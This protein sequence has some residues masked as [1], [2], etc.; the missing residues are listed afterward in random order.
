M[1][2][3]QRP[4]GI[5]I[6]KKFGE[7]EAELVGEQDDDKSRDQAGDRS[8][9]RNPRK[10]ANCQR[11]REQLQ[12]RREG[13]GADLSLRLRRIGRAEQGEQ[14]SE[15]DADAAEQLL[16]PVACR[17]A[18]VVTVE[19]AREHGAGGGNVD[20]RGSLRRRHGGDGEQPEK[21]RRPRRRAS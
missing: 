9:W 16:V 8:P 21:P 19:V 13:E 11:R 18:E 10:P 14:H 1:V 12:T 17:R 3:G 4:H 5:S 7:C 2:H 20:R 6:S 15:P